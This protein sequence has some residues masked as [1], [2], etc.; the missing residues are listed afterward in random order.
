MDICSGFEAGSYFRLVDFCMR[1]ESNKEEGSYLRPIDFCA[2]LESNN[3]EERDGIAGHLF[4]K[5]IAVQASSLQVLE[6]SPPRGT[7]NTQSTQ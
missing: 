4:P 3:E 2:R 7:Q 6:G 5:G 1:L